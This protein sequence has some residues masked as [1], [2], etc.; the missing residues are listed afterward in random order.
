MAMRLVSS[1]G[2]IA[3]ATLL[4]AGVLT[5]CLPADAA[6][7]THH[8]AKHAQHVELGR[9]TSIQPVTSEA[10]TTGA[11]VALGAIAGGVLGHQIGSGS[12]NTLATVAGA[13][14]GAVLGNQ[15][16]R[17]H[18]QKK[19]IGYRVTVR[20]DDGKAR[21]FEASNLAG[22]KVG[23]RVRIDGGVLRHA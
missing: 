23:D 20:A 15:I 7:A 17:N 13:T 14:G 5:A 4:A 18:R 9:V 6:P 3:T 21:V 12:G 11:G 8:V 19:V 2:A 1:Y 22:L 16:E 10:R